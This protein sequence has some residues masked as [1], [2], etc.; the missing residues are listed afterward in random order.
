MTRMPIESTNCD[1]YHKRQFQTRRLFSPPSFLRAQAA[2]PLLVPLIFSTPLCKV[3]H[4]I[5]T[6]FAER[7]CFFCKKTAR[8]ITDRAI[9][10][11]FSVFHKKAPAFLAR[12][13]GPPVLKFD[14][15]II[16]QNR[17]SAIWQKRKST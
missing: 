4:Q 16:F 7:C 3:R 6:V 1:C 11:K 15:I 10:K 17:R 14:S 13:R 12:I 9:F 5:L 8:F 2:K